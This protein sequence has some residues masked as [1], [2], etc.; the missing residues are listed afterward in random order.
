MGITA[1]SVI[2]H[3]ERGRSPKTSVLRSRT[4][5]TPPSHHPGL[6]PAPGLPGSARG[7]GSKVR[8]GRSSGGQGEAGTGPARAWQRVP[9]R[10]GGA[11]TRGVQGAPVARCWGRPPRR[12]VRQGPGLGQPRGR[13]GA[14]LSLRPPPSFPPARPAAEISSRGNYAD[15][16]RGSSPRPRSPPPPLRWGAG[17]RPRRRG[18][19]GSLDREVA[20]GRGDVVLP[21]DAALR[22]AIPSAPRA[23]ARALSRGTSCCCPATRAHPPPR[24]PRSIPASA[25]RWSLPGS[26]YVSFAAPSWSAPERSRRSPTSPKV[27]DEC[28]NQR[29]C[30]L[31]VNSRVFGPDL[32]PG[33]SKYLLVSFKCQPNEL[34]NKTVCEDHELKLHCH[35]SK[36]L[37]IYSAT[38]GRRTQERDVCTSEAGR[39]PPF[40]CLSYSALHVLS[41]RCYGKQRC[42]VLVNNHHF[43][44][45]CLPGVKKYLSVFY[46]CVPKNILTAID[47]SVANIKPSVKQKDGDYGVDLDPREPRILRKD[48]VIVS[49]SLAA[50]AYIRVGVCAVRC[51]WSQR[52]CPGLGLCITHLPGRTPVSM[53]LGPGEDRQLLRALTCSLLYSPPRESRPAVR[54]QRLHRSGAHAVCVGHQSV[55]HQ[56]PP[57]AAAGQGA[58]GARKRQGRGGQP[59]R[60]GGGGL[61]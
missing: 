24:N 31:L 59:G 53:G 36:F 7:A 16:S 27:L 48:G 8:H 3:V 25:G 58:P 14:T 22:P 45:P 9:G 20:G 44:S 15:P 39:L 34:K 60:G 54:V 37:N 49:H 5:R 46:A 30:H 29:A 42:K 47:P 51:G 18:G 33:S 12:A 10:L 56:G 32:C 52:C 6:G 11:G 43:G 55:L 4:S 26:S 23:R 28:Q 21:C 13:R 38:Y 2:L 35:E 61:L 40:D 57:G 17:A 41:R 50:F 19:A 1:C